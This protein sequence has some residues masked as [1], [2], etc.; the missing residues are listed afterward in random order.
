MKSLFYCLKQNQLKYN[1]LQI[2][3]LNHK[4]VCFTLPL[5]NKDRVQFELNALDFLSLLA[6]ESKDVIVERTAAVCADIEGLAVFLYFL[7]D[8]LGT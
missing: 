7:H 4:S 8:I 5:F 2:L 3:L 1:E 6:F